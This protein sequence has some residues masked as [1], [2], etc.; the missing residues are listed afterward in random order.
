MSADGLISMDQ[1]GS[2]QH[3]KHSTACF[4]RLYLLTRDTWP[5]APFTWSLFWSSAAGPIDAISDGGKD[6]YEKKVE[7]GLQ[8][9]GGS[10]IT[11]WLTK[12]ALAN[13][14]RDVYGNMSL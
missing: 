5:T 11:E 10:V 13:S 9:Y 6:M 8:N 4:Y 3:N 2:A 14:A 1:H 12:K 7:V